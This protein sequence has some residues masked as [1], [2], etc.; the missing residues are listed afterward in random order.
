MKTT[1]L[2]FALA[3]AMV[4]FATGCASS[5]DAKRK[6]T[7]TEVVFVMDYGTGRL[8]DENILEPSRL[9]SISEPETGL[10]IQSINGTDHY[11][12]KNLKGKTV[13]EVRELMGEEKLSAYLML[14]SALTSDS[15][16]KRYFYRVTVSDGQY[17]IYDMDREEIVE[18][19]V[20]G[21][22]HND[23]SEKVH[24]EV[25]LDCMFN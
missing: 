14:L 12:G 9:K 11:E 15:V 21:D 24:A 18:S 7:G 17:F 13:D 8:N 6:D 25:L 16:P 20:D 10:V 22:K 23:D 19:N 5:P 4:L 3:A 1:K 2:F